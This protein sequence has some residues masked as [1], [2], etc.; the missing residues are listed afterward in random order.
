M[1]FEDMWA[2]QERHWNSE[3]IRY[4]YSRISIND[5]PQPVDLSPAQ[6]NDLH[7]RLCTHLSGEIEE[8]V[9]TADWKIHSKGS[10]ATTRTI[11][12]EI[13]DVQ[14]FLINLAVLHGVT[15]DEFEEAFD[16]KSDVVEQR[17]L[18]EVM[19]QK[20]ADGKLGPVLV[21][22]LDGVLCARDTALIRFANARCGTIC[23][24]CDLARMP[25]DHCACGTCTR[26]GKYK[27]F[28]REVP[29][30]KSTSEFR[31]NYG[32]KAYETL[33]RDF[34][35]SGGFL[36]TWVCVAALNSL[37]RAR[38][39]GIPILICTSRDIKRYP[40]LEYETHKWLA[41]NGVPYDGII[42]AAEK[43][44]AL[45]WIDRRSIAIDDEQEHID[46]LVFV[47]DAHKYYMN[48]PL[49]WAVTKLWEIRN[50][51]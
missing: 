34:Y 21:C 4:G 6:V 14:K 18:L 43:E 30:V 29:P 51:V 40:H 22:D 13:I 46:K 24:E 19:K 8:L 28:M 11:L 48:D 5:V 45:T 37:K 33:K 15:P 31:A 25:G 9:R 35:E 42:F 38:A 39:S 47:C 2:R 7:L 23:R 49:E 44:R 12:Q 17:V 41:Y 20:A 16:Q 1:S 3:L 32:Q 26:C 27:E 10:L 50:A 36:T